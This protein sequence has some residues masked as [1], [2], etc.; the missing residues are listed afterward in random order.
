MKVFVMMILTL[1]NVGLIMVTVV[2]QIRIQIIALNAFAMFKKVAP[3]DFIHQLVM[4]IVMMK[5]ITLNAILM[6][7]TAVDPQLI[8]HFVHYVHVMVS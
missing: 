7:L 1:E 8:P 2:C 6:V 5:Q 4:A 3:L